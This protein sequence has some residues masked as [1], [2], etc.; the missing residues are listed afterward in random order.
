[1]SN[2]KLAVF[3][4]CQTAY[5]SS[6]ITKTA[7]TKGAQKSIGW[8]PS[9]GASAHTEWLKNFWSRAGKEFFLSNAVVYADSFIYSDNGVKQHNQ[10]GNWNQPLKTASKSE[11]NKSST[12]FRLDDRNNVVDIDVNNFNDNQII[13]S[14]STWIVNNI[15]SDFN[16]ANY[17]IEKTTQEDKNIY[18]IKLTINGNI[19]TKLG[20]TA[21]VSNGKITNIFNNMDNKNNK[22]LELQITQALL[23]KNAKSLSTTNIVE[24]ANEKI[25]FDIFEKISQETYS[26]FDDADG[27]IYQIVRTE[28]KNKND[29]TFY[30]DEY[31]IEI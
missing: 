2:V 16:I 29:G 26:F 18:D 20:Y 13:N 30:V 27:K 6:N 17:E 9:I 8:I 14:I 25:D 19:K 1:M 28:L 11:Y 4:G 24:K 5:G 7:Q 31:K 15:N 21:F 10:Y 23:Q 22:N 12:P 3:A